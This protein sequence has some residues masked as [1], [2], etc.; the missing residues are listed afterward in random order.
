[1]LFSFAKSEIPFLGEIGPKIKNIHF[2]TKLGI[3]YNLLIYYLNLMIQK[4]LLSSVL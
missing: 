2:G 1:M 4:Q 3:V